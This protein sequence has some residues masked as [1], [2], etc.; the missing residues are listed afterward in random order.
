MSIMYRKRVLV[1]DDEDNVRRVVQ[2]CLE[3]LAGWDVLVAASGEEGLVIAN[4]EQPDAILLDGMMPGMDG[5]T[6]MHHHQTD[7]TISSIPV[8]FLTAK[9]CLTEPDQYIVLGVK[10]AIAKPFAPLTL[11]VHVANIL[12]WSPETSI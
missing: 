10:G 2:A 1:I 9:I 6:F 8:V 12:G 7:P 11:A 3:N 4:R 5:V